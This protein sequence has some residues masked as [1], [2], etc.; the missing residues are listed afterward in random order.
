[1]CHTLIM[2]MNQINPTGIPHDQV[3]ASGLTMGESIERVSTYADEVTALE[4]VLSPAQLDQ[5][6]DLADQWACLPFEA[7]ERALAQA[8]N[9]AA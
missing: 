2:G 8:T 6:T 1:M 9:S 4:Q 3:L 5:V 7:L